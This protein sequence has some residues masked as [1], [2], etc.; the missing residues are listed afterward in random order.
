MP[1]RDAIVEAPLAERTVS[2]ML[3]RNVARHPDKVAIRATAGEAL[4]YRELDARASRMA[5]GLAA[6][7]IGAGDH[8]LVM[9]TDTVDF[10]TVWCGLARR[11]AVQ[12]P[13]NLAYRGAILRRICNDSG[14][15]TIII[16]RQY[17]DRLADVADELEHLECCVIYAED[18]A[19]RADLTL[20]PALAGRCRAAAFADLF[21]AEDTPFAPEP[22]FNDMTA[23]MYTSGTTGASK[24]VMITEAQA[25]RYA[26]GAA[27]CY[28][29]AAEDVIYTAGLPLFHIAGQWAVC[30]AALIHGATIILR[31]GYRNKHF[32]SDIAEHGCTGTLLLGAIAN[33]LWQQTESPDDAGTPL[34]KVVMGPVMAE[35]EAFA[36]RFGVRISTAYASTEDPV[37]CVQFLGEPYPNNQCVGYPLPDF[38]VRIFDEFDRDRAPGVMGEICVRPGNAWDI[39]L[40]YWNQPDYTARVFRNLWYHTGDAGYRDEEGRI[41]FVDRLTDSMRRRG[42]NI[43]SM[44]VE[45]EI[46][47]HADVLECAVFPVAAEHGEQEVMAAITP[48]PGRE[49]EPA[50]LIRFLDRRMPYFMV[51]RYLDFTDALP[52][53]PTGKVQKYILREKGVTGATWDRVA[54]GVKLTR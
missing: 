30:Y 40:G 10:I 11:G 50:E 21:A 20:P 24:G 25:Y 33:F 47:Q 23:I 41:Y 12:V 13:V 54:A 31:K 9:L 35:H 17:L 39:M 32:W 36:E 3:A 28:D 27:M 48:K 18:P 37:P 46:N 38:E 16:D 8:V 1:R 4:T 7:G 51:P 14:A 53:T 5:H 52:K 2:H 29:M 19:G 26:A 6:F 49:I 15:R 22:A 45:D 43:S 34:R 42:E 44:E